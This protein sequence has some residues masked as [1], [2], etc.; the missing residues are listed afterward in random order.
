M[1]RPYLKLYLIKEFHN[2]YWSKNNNDKFYIKH[3]PYSQ[4]KEKRNP[5]ARS[6]GVDITPQLKTS[7]NSPPVST[8]FIELP[9][10]FGT[11]KMRRHLCSTTVQAETPM[12]KKCQQST[13]HFFVPIVT[14]QTTQQPVVN[15]LPGML[16]YEQKRET[17]R[18]KSVLEASKT[19]CISSEMG[20]S[21]SISKKVPQRNFSI[22]SQMNGWKKK[23]KSHV[24]P[25]NIV[26]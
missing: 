16:I 21:F 14:L 25:T 20:D 9:S 19:Y 6:H 12:P 22:Y 5:G 26:K 10:P 23:I 15:S 13:D 17:L 2:N 24:L 1:V 8:S 7:K 18:L 11:F 3:V 4:A